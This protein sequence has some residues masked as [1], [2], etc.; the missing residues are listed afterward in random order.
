MALRIGGSAES[1]NYRP[2]GKFYRGPLLGQQQNGYSNTFI[3][4]GGFAGQNQ[5]GGQSGIN[6][7]RKNPTPEELEEQALRDRAEKY[8]NNL[9]EYNLGQKE[10]E[11][12]SLMGGGQNST[13]SSFG[14]NSGLPPSQGG[15]KGGSLTNSSLMGGGQNSTTPNTSI[16]NDLRGFQ[17]NSSEFLSRGG[18]LGEL[19]NYLSQANQL[20]RATGQEGN[21]MDFILGSTPSK[22]DQMRQYNLKTFQRAAPGIDFPSIG[23]SSS[24]SSN[25]SKTLSSEQKKAVAGIPSSDMYGFV[26]PSARPYFN[27][28]YYQKGGL[29][30]PSSPLS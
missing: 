8:E 15:G 19:T 2:G 28:D 20:F 16:I 23:G 5:I 13:T 4:T 17:N 26:A 29:S 7:Y 21:L 27:A 24:S 22:Q 30:A 10:A 18:D 1:D 9:Y 3:P 6:I 14:S 25:M 11:L 12:A